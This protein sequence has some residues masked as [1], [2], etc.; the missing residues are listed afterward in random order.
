VVGNDG[1]AY[2]LSSERAARATLAGARSRD[3]R[4]TAPVPTVL[5]ANP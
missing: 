4:R 1:V 2:L 5:L 3:S